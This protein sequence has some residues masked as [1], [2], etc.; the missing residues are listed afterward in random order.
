MCVDVLYV[1]IA[2]NV[3]SQVTEEADLVV[4]YGVTMD[5]PLTARYWKM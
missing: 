5:S 4:R 3:T 2:R 1:S